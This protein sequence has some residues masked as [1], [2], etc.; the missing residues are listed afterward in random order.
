MR[1]K[2]ADYLNGNVHIQLYSDGTRIME[3]EADEFEFDRPV[4]IDLTITKACDGGCPYCYMNCTPEGKLANLHHPILKS[5][6]EYQELAINLND[7]EIPDLVPFLTRMKQRH[8]FVNGTINQVHFLKHWK[9]L[10][11][12]CGKRLLWGLGVSL[13]NPTP[14]FI[15]IVQK[16]PNAVIH[17]I[18]GVL[19]A[20]DIE[21][22]RDKGLKLLI[23]GYK[24][25]GRGSDYVT[26]NEATIKARQQYLR[27]VLPTM[28]HHFSVVSFDNL[29]IEQLGVKDI[30]TDE[31]W[32]S[33][34]QGD[35]GS[36]TMFMDLVE[37]K[38]GVS[39]LCREEEM[40]PLLGSVKEM[41]DIVRK[42]AK[43]S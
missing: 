42:E 37:E 2:I 13:R 4:N 3:T 18:N 40:R 32:D 36:A 6:G 14:E 26:E 43:A 33:F 30:L 31:E 10:K 7:M 11:Q 38:F 28:F 15:S 39:S 21:K 25:L 24:N 20:S 35:E 27:D 23:L 34:Y 17:V 41:F 9:L 22:M 5:L 16:F 29:A 8:I 12:L 19:S 1:R